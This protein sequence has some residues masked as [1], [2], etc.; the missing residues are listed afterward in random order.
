MRQNC[1]AEQVRLLKSQTPTLYEPPFTH[2]HY[3]QVAHR[4]I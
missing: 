3:N 2:V 1:K 4:H